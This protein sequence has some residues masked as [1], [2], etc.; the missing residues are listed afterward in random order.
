MAGVEE[1]GL[2]PTQ[3]QARLLSAR[4]QEREHVRRILWRL[5][6]PIMDYLEYGEP[7]DEEV[8][9]SP[10]PFFPNVP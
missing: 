7:G 3:L 2:G 4:Q 9:V 6:Q 1:G 5:L 10:F 8:G